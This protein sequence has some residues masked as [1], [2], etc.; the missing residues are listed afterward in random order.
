MWSIRRY[1]SHCI[2][3]HNALHTNTQAHKVTISQL[4]QYT[5]TR[6]HKYTID[7]E[8]LP[9][10]CIRPTMAVVIN[11]L[12]RYILYCIRTTTMINKVFTLRVGL[13]QICLPNLS[14]L[15]R[16]KHFAWNYINYDQSALINKVLHF[17]THYT[18]YKRSKWL[19]WIVLY[20]IRRKAVINTWRH[21]SQ[22]PTQPYDL[23]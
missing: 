4:H 20:L 6:V 10:I 17:S 5:S 2:Q 15:Q 9:V 16:F 22:V 8:L 13:A 23:Q 3:I 18:H 14:F 21:I 19:W 12:R 11:K 1:I 7:T